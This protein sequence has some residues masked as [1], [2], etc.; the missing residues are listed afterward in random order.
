MC[1]DYLR[2]EFY[3]VIHN[4]SVYILHNDALKHLTYTYVCMYVVHGTAI[5]FLK[6]YNN[7]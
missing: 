6:I 4:I 2:T 5:E 7:E 3:V 1:A